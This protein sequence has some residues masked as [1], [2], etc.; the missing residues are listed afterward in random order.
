MVW[1]SSALFQFLFQFSNFPC[2][3]TITS[4][5]DLSVAHFISH[6]RLIGA[7][8]LRSFFRLSSHHFN[9]NRRLSYNKLI[10]RVYFNVVIKCWRL[11]VI[12]KRI[13]QSVKLIYKLISRLNTHLNCFLQTTHSNGFSPIF[14]MH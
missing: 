7:V 1:K 5:W 4:S 3:F 2:V 6:L 8:V 13:N 12:P 9:L 11:P 14:A 10:T